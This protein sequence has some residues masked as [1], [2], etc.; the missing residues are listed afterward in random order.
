MLL[1]TTEAVSTTTEEP[2]PRKGGYPK[3]RPRDARTIIDVKSMARSHAPMAINVLRRLA[4]NPKVSGAVRVAAATA[5][6]DRGFGRPSQEVQ[7][8][9]TGQ[10]TISWEG[11]T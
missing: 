10:I 4:D 2:T 8:Q 5:L 7:A 1:D 9:L 6:L 11:E 3:G